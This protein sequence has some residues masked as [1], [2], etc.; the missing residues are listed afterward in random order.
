MVGKTLGHYEILEPLGAGGMGEVYRARDTKLDRDVAIK[1]LP[2]DFATDPERLARFERE[3][4]LLASLNHANIATIHGLEDS[5]GVRFIAMELVEGET[6]A[7]RISRSGRIEVDEAL[8]IARQIAEALEAAHE[9]GVIHRD[10]RPANVI[11]TPE[12]NVKV[13]D[14]GLAK[15]YETSGSSPDVS[16][17]MSHSPTM[18][19][20]TRTGVI[21]GTAAY[22]SPEQARGKAVD[23]RADIWAFGCVVYEMLAGKPTFEGSDAAELLVSVMSKE[24]E[25]EG[26]PANTPVALG[27][28]LRRCLQKD[29]RKRLRHIGD[30]GYDIGEALAEPGDPSPGSASRT[31]PGWRATLP[32]GVA[33]AATLVA[34][35]LGVAPFLG[36]D[37]SD[38]PSWLEIV[39]PNSTAGIAPEPALSPDG[40]KIVFRAQNDDGDTKLWLRRFDSQVPRELPGTEDG[41]Q[42]FWSP[43]SQSIGFF[44]RDRAKMKRFD[45]VDDGIRELADVQNPRGGSWGPNGEILYALNAFG[46]LYAVSDTGGG[47]PTQVTALGDDQLGHLYPHLLPDGTHFLYVGAGRRGERFNVYLGSLDSPETQRLDG[48]HS[49]AEFVDGHLLFGEGD[50]LYAQRFDVEGARLLGP[51]IHL[52]DGMGVS[53]GEVA[54]AALSS[55]QGALIFASGGI[56]P[57]TRLVFIDRAGRRLESP[58]IAGE[59]WGFVPSPDETQ[60]AIEMRDPVANKVNVVLA[61]L[62]DGTP[63]RLVEGTPYANTPMW[64]ST[65][66]RV[67]STDFTRSYHITNVRDT[68]AVEMVEHADA[69]GGGWLTDWHD[70]YLV[71]IQIDA[72][73][74]SD[75]WIHDLSTGDAH[76]YLDSASV[77]WEPRV[78]PTGRWLAYVSDE[79]D[80]FAVYV[81]AFPERGDKE[82][83]SQAGGRRPTWGPSGNDLYYVRSDD[84]MLMVAT[85]VEDAGGLKVE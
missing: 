30:A 36:P 51:R 62:A 75:V 21:M 32:W 19:E 12:G 39:P 42:P 76:A 70:Q 58:E 31:Q 15:A 82:R 81:Q 44:D 84:G 53:F 20:A 23:K 49:R 5:D 3:A 61:D 47:E 38:R 16:P 59:I 14:F 9:N 77:E 72:A 34:A 41:S 1:V 80:E 56:S 6:L 74:L 60:V 29:R 85:L 69:D 71:I 24:P 67:I 52:A 26:L 83:I 64:E 45:L 43:D 40:E 8:N 54:G 46:P 2:E 66:D 27:R 73:T 28:L 68:E 11:V 7:E 17:D 50:T 79:Q 25:W 13:L 33:T 48:I 10:L 22:M 18:M 37:V 55:G 78:S 65:G 4:K 63:T 57:D 35:A